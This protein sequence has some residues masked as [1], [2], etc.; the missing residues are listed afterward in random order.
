MA[1]TPVAPP[2]GAMS[3][4]PSPSG[5]SGGMPMNEGAQ[6]VIRVVQMV[7]ELSQSNPEVAG[8][9]KQIN[10]LLQKIN[11]KMMQKSKPAEP[12]APPV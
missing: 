3:G 10:D 5:D 4:G 12:P 1:S 9:V 6:K 11:M 7:R 8:E 2:P